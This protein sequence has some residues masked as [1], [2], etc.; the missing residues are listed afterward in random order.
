MDLS[1]PKLRKILVGV[2]IFVVVVFIV[3]R[4]FR[5]SNYAYPNA[6][7]EGTFSITAVPTLTAAAGA[8]PALATFTTTAP[9]GFSAGDL[10]YISGVTGLTYTEPVTGFPTGAG[11]PTGGSAMY[12]YSAS[13][14]TFAVKAT[15]TVAGTAP[16]LATATV[17]SMV[18]PAMNKMQNTDL[19]AC[20]TQYATDLVTA[21]STLTTSASQSIISG[22]NRLVNVIST[23]G[24]AVD[25]KV[26]I[27]GVL[28]A[29][30]KA[31]VLVIESV[32]A[33][34]LTFKATSVPA[35]AQTIL[36]QTAVSNITTAYAKRSACIQ[37]S[38][39]TF[40]IGHC[41][42]L[43]QVA[44]NRPV[45]PLQSDDPVAY[46]AYQTYQ[47]DIQTIQSAYAAPIS[48][49]T[50]NSSFPTGGSVT[51]TVLTQAQQQA[52]VEAARKADLA[53]ATQ[54]YLA[55]VCPGFYA[56]TS[57]S[58]TTDPS[59]AYKA[60][61]TAQSDPTS[62][63]TS[64][65]KKF[66]AGGV[67]DASIMAWAQGAGI[68]TLSGP[69]S[70]V[71]IPGSGIG[72]YSSPPTGVTFSAPPAGGTTATGTPVMTSGKITGVTITSGGSGYTT[73]PTIT[74]FTGG[75]ATTA[76]T[77]IELGTIVVQI[78]TTLSAT[79]PIVPAATTGFIPSGGAAIA[80]SATKYTAGTG[81][82]VNWRVAYKNGP[83]TYPKVTYA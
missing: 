56:Q 4:F 65:A 46:A 31:A 51:G 2:A 19:L 48:R 41:R 27:P 39:T 71:T 62:T 21:T 68:V 13:G 63:A 69:V 66:W 7:E 24:F 50:Q 53:N 77:S 80:Y 28:D 57:G 9:H 45:V 58:T 52:I 81:D 15:Q 74:G 60:W 59:N 29:N 73:N 42:Y 61:S 55:S 76:P 23:T 44:T 30:S 5:R 38:A 11:S 18:Q 40:T 49:V 70:S 12:L 26:L 36:P 75:T 16:V 14:S 79:G 83:G 3:I 33:G 43:P 8:T 1:S 32:A 20:Q 47:T 10:V 6:S 17:K 64:T 34:S 72:T 82:S 54:K 37:T 35:T 25:D 78:S 67:T 22:G